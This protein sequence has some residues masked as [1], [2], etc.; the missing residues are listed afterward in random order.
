[1][2][3]SAVHPHDEGTPMRRVLSGSEDDM[4]SYVRERAELAMP[5]PKTVVDLVGIEDGRV[6]TSIIEEISGDAIVLAVP[7]DRERRSVRPEPGTR[8]EL[9]WKDPD[10]LLA[11]PVQ[12]VAGEAAAELRVRRTG[13]PTA[14]QRRSTVRAPL[15]LP[16]QLTRGQDEASGLTV[17]ISEGGLRCVLDTAGPAP[18]STD[19]P[20]APPTRE[21]AVGD[22]IA[23][24]VAL[25]TG[26]MQGCGEVVRR[27]SR[28][29]GRSEL[30]LRFVELPEATQDLIRR[31]VFTGLRDLRLRGL[32]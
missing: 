1:M 22:R 13:S 16:V 28:D 15:L 26:V 30:S 6:A 7:Q 3:N 17:D 31:R 20:A 21:M 5:G 9:V 10:G 32:I 4:P 8:L 29:D 25:D 23:V 12:V 2:Q 19:G 24:V 14:G 18:A 27:H 11:L